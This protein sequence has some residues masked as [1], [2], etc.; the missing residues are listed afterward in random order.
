MVFRARST[1]KVLKAEMLPKSTN[2]VTYLSGKLRCVCGGVRS[3]AEIKCLWVQ[4]EESQRI[5][6][7][8]IITRNGGAGQITPRFPLIVQQ[9]RRT[10][11]SL[12]LESREARTALLTHWL[13]G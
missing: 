1:R 10:V 7:M 6:V 9:L 2:S 3:G 8:G 5:L 13:C 11:L 4:N 12:L